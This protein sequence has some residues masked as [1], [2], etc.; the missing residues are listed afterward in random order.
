MLQESG[1]PDL[2]AREVCSLPRGLNQRYCVGT[3]E[4][5]LT[6]YYPLL[7]FHGGTNDTTSRDSDSVKRGYRALGAVVKGLGS[8]M[9]FSVLLIK[10]KDLRRRALIVHV[11]NQLWNWSW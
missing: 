5:C 7:I 9:V 6:L 2:S 4:A 8:Q 11:N 1:S 10:G 3:T